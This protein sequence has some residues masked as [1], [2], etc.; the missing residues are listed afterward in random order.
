MKF[1]KKLLTVGSTA[2]LATLAGGFTLK[3]IRHDAS[4]PKEMTLVTFLQD[5]AG[6][7]D[8]PRTL[9]R[10]SEKF[11]RLEETPDPV[12][13]IHGLMVV[14]EPDIW[15]INQMDHSGKH[16]VDTGPTYNFVAPILATS[17]LFPDGV[18][19]ETLRSLEYGREVE[20]FAANHAK[21]LGEKA[22]LEKNGFKFILWK[23]PESNHP[24]RLEVFQN[25]NH[26]FDVIYL[27]YETGLPFDA[28]LFQPPTG[29]QIT[30]YK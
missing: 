29:I 14:S 1:S 2:A 18:I 23:D 6:K 9:I 16:A 8:Q 11:G 22:E 7:R 21:N 27:K 17:R 26:V 25:A 15:M 19:P 4:N 12:G 28:E 10:A 30:E 13:G 20:Y 24:R 5:W 3:A